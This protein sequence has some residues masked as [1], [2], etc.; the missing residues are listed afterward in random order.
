MGR[1]D[2][3]WMCRAEVSGELVQSV[4][5]RRGDG[6]TVTMRPRYRIAK[7][8]LRGWRAHDERVTMARLRAL[9]SDLI[10][11]TIAVH[12]GRVV[13]RIGDGRIVEF[14]SVVDMERIARRRR[15]YPNWRVKLRGILRPHLALHDL[16]VLT[17]P[18]G[19]RGP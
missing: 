1:I 13:K 9:F 8:P 6:A 16:E 3:V 15:R 5:W 10:D 4:E 14:R 7:L 12:N 19:T 18:V 2:E 11:P 17:L